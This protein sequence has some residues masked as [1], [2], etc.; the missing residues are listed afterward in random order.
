MLVRIADTQVA[1]QRQGGLVA[2]GQCTLAA[3]LAEHQEDVQVEVDIAQFEADQLPTAGAGVEQEHDEDRQT[4]G[5]RS[6]EGLLADRCQPVGAWLCVLLLRPEGRFRP[7]EAV[8]AHLA[9]L[10]P[11]GSG[12]LSG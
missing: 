6:A 1:I 4:A 3:T 10:A 11:L 7:Y 2:E 12:G 9:I 5:K 8:P